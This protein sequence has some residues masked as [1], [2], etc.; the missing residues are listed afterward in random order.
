[1]RTTLALVCISTALLLTQSAPAATVTSTADSGSGSLRDTIATAPPGDT[2]NFA[3]TGNIT[4]TSGELLINKSLNIVGPGAASLTIERST[5]LG[6]TNFRVFNVQSGIV[7]ISGLT[8]SNGRAEGG[9]GLRN[10]ATL[11]VRDTVFS[12]NVANQTGGGIENVSSLVLSNCVI[13]GN[14]VAGT[15]S[16]AGGG[17]HNLGTVTALSCIVS[18]NILSRSGASIAC[19]GGG[20]NNDGTLAMTNSIIHGN[21]AGTSVSADVSGGGIFNN[22]TLTLHT[23]TVGAN[24]ANSTSGAARGGGIANGFGTV[25][26]N[27]STV[28]FNQAARASGG[29]LGGGLFNDLGTL[30]VDNS[31]ISG[32]QARTGGS[33]GVF[34]G[35]GSV[36]ITHSTLTANFGAS[37]FGGGIGGLRNESGVVTLSNNILA[38]NT[39]T[40]V[41]NGSQGLLTTS[42]SV[43]GTTAGPIAAGPGNQFNVTAAQLRIG[44]LKDNGGPTFTHALLC[45][46]PA[47]N[48]GDNTN[49]P[50]T[51][52]RG[53]PRII[54]GTIDVGSFELDNTAPTI[55]CEQ[56]ITACL[57]DTNQIEV[58]V[59]AQV[60]DANGDALIVFWS[61]G[62]IPY[63]TN[64]VPAGVPPTTNIVQVTAL[65]GLGMHTVTAAVFDPSDCGNSCSTPVTVTTGPI[66]MAMN[67]G[68]ICAGRTLMLAA[69]SP[70]AVSFHWTGPNG[71]TSPLQNPVIPN[72]TLAA[73]GDYT[74]VVMDAGGCTGSATT[75]AEVQ[76]D[77]RG[78]LYPIALSVKNVEGVP[79]GTVIAD[80]Y[81][82]VQPGNFGWLTWA[83]S[84]SEP[85][86]MTSLKPPGDSDTYINPYNP[87][88]R[89]LSVGDWVQGRPGV[90][91]SSSV[92]RQLD[93]LST[94]NI[95]VPV[96]DQAVSRGNNSL[97]R[98]VAFARVRIV[99]YRLPNVNR[100]SARFLGFVGCDEAEVS[101]NGIGIMN[102]RV[103][104]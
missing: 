13:H 11:T 74:V 37:P 68:P 7:N 92:R 97:Y 8:V 29:G 16:R 81:N 27:R 96:Y 41:V 49:A 85:T 100:I 98:V 53:F 42:F 4:L 51:D 3:V 76:D 69:V 55:L 9:G 36:T 32:N 102:R 47:I 57:A 87:R 24:S 94:R 103:T 60:S 35:F 88:D 21:S 10:Q 84:P 99:D 64:F 66:V 59:S 61:I 82:G 45:G 12:G 17:L 52:Q 18:S 34:N 86:L 1:M 28:S 77:G 33:G 80:I 38:A 63:Q 48:A 2:I 73:S 5:A 56:P 46:S 20:I 15:N 44:P 67:N 83:G 26:L 71:F 72:A 101:R 39:G 78:E 75:T 19:L 31:T 79:I 43:I 30:S 58:T 22:G 95:V 40:D 50:P 89:V 90:A 25:T 6:T 91:N 23:S 70:T 104:E 54:G 14:S 93:I 65:F 62:G